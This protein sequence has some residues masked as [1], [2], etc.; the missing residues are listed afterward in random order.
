MEIIIYDEKGLEA[1]LI[2]DIMG[3]SITEEDNLMLKYTSDG[4]AILYASI[5]EDIFIKLSKKQNIDKPIDFYEYRVGNTKKGYISIV[6]RVNITNIFD[7][8][9]PNSHHQLKNYETSCIRNNMSFKDENELIT[10][11]MKTHKLQIL[12]CCEPSSSC[13]S[14]AYRLK[15]KVFDVKCILSCEVV[16]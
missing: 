11:Y 13:T 5:K 2:H 3:G 6:A 7:T 15:Y 9:I 12:R 8:L 4:I 14:T 16:K 10:A 1:P